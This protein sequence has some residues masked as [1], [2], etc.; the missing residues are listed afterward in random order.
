MSEN[1][2]KL[3]K[4]FTARTDHG[5]T[6]PEG[7]EVLSAKFGRHRANIWLDPGPRKI[8]GNDREVIAE[9]DQQ[10]WRISAGC[11]SI[12]T[13][14]KV[15]MHRAEAL[16]IESSYGSRALADHQFTNLATAEELA[17]DRDELG[18]Q[19]AEAVAARFRYENRSTTSDGPE[20]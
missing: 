7:V 15:A 20:F 18:R 8:W 13:T 12:A 6:L 10:I 11:G 19:N 14:L 1:T 2:E 4:T 17:A 16:A 3:G 5:L 9:L